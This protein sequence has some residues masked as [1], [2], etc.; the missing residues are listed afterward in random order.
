MMRMMIP[1]QLNSACMGSWVMFADDDFLLLMLQFF[2]DDEIMR[3]SSSTL[4]NSGARILLIGH[5]EFSRFK[6]VLKVS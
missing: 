3:P 6:I 4:L 2:S 1:V 5:V